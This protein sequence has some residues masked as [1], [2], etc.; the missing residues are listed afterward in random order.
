[1]DKTMMIWEPDNISGLWLNEVRVGEM[2]GNS[3][4]FYGGLFGAKGQSII[5]HGYNG[6]FHY[7]K[8][9]QMDNNEI[10]ESQ[11]AISGHFDEIYDICWHP[12]G[13]Y[14]LSVS[15][16]QTSRIFS[17]WIKENKVVT[18][19]EIARP[20]IHGYDMVCATF[21]PSKAHCFISGADEKIFRVFM[22]SKSFMQ[23]LNKIA[24]PNNEFS[25]SEIKQ[26]E[27]LEKSGL[28]LGANVPALGL[29]NKPV[30]SE[31][32]YAGEES[33]AF[34]EEVMIKAAAPAFVEQPP[35]EEQLL[36]ATLWP[37][38]QKLYGHGNEVICIACDH[39]GKYLA[40]AC[41]A[42]TPDQA[43]IRIWDTETWRQKTPLTIHSLTVTQ[44][45][46]SHNDQYLLSCS[47]DREFA[48]SKRNED[49]S[50]NVLCICKKAHQRIVW[51]C[52][53]S[54]D[55]K[56]ILTG[57]RDKFVK[58]WKFND[59]KVDCDSTLPTFD[60]AVTAVV[61][62]PVN[63]ITNNHNYMACIGL[64]NGQI[65]IWLASLLGDSL[66]WYCASVFNQSYCHVSTV[67]R[68]CFQPQNQHNQHTDNKKE[69][70][71]NIASC[72]LDHSVRLFE[73]TMESN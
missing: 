72:S 37:E 53:W 43:V 52:S 29:S 5:A 51:T 49:N 55:D 36:Q 32:D 57:A 42:T 38:I 60:F 6:T 7:W 45:E 68:L 12:S 39:H 25:Q 15:K 1:M 65:S 73:V 24:K 33:L 50:M 4:G 16:D 30:F 10:W 61:W 59:D 19:H 46:F 69:K 40:T 66:S 27:Q 71:F 41:K 56:F 62:A 21:I 54:P 13:D 23:N 18:W 26:L 58:C 3:L 63:Q 11:V 22:G 8:Q 34:Q 20:Q 44:L 67:R 9:Q 47:R 35:F 28:A 48:V 70:K 17:P 31:K 14:L 2:G 64:E